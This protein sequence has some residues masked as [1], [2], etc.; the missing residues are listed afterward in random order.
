MDQIAERDHTLEAAGLTYAILPYTPSPDR[1]AVVSAI[2][3]GLCHFE[4]IFTDYN[5]ACEAKC[6][7][8]EQCIL[9]MRTV[10]GTL[11]HPASR[12]WEVWQQSVESFDLVGVLY[13]T[14]VIPGQDAVAHYVFFDGRLH[15]KTA[16]VESMIQWVF[17]DHEDWQ[18]LKRLTI[19]IPDFAFAL[20]R[21]AH[22]H[23]GF[24][25]DFPFTHK[26]VS[27]SV[28]GVRRKALRWRDAERNL[29]VLGRINGSA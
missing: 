23:L 29:L 17:E 8:C 16:L 13:L 25:G 10:A 19:E 1:A 18:A 14:D 27:I 15:D 24:G 3:R 12:V 7:Q 9:C 22:K 28:E 2:L 4:T 21:H 20:A 11:T 5:K 26:H 6:F